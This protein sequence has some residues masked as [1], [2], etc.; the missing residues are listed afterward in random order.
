M[1]EELFVFFIVLVI[2]LLAKSVMKREIL[3]AF[4]PIVLRMRFIGVAIHEFSHYIMCLVVGIKPEGIEI[5]WR[6]KETRQRDPH[7][8][9]SLKPY[10]FFQAVLICLAPLYISTW[11]IFFSFTIIK[12]PNYNPV[13]RIIAIFFCISLFL[14]AAPSNTDFN[15]IPKIFR[16]YPQHSC[17]QIF[18]LVIS[19]LIS[20]GILMYT[21]V[22]FILDIFYY[23]AII[24]LYLLLK[25]SFLGVSRGISEIQSRNFRN[26]SKVRL[27]RFTRTYYKPKKPHKE[28]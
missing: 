11:L 12:N 16:R 5:N 23:L 27:R 21:Q 9:V 6:V 18:L 24:G 22:V 28:W 10:S 26:H 1:L 7:G 14:G 20:W 3:G 25:F 8:K 2:S 19:V 15:I 4:F 13:V 17:Y